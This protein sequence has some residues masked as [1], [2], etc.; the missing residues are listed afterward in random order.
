MYHLPKTV[1]QVTIPVKKAAKV[2]GDYWKF[3][4]CFFSGSELESFTSENKSSFSLGDHISS[5][6]IPDTS[7]T[8]VI[9]TKGKYFENKT[10]FVEYAPNNSVLQKDNPNRRMKLWNSP[11][12]P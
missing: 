7:V 10:L 12:K 9:K 1:V 8:Y 3:A 5:K 4:P 2:R 11:L 6:G